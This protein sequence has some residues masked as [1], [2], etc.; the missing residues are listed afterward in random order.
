M[1][2]TATFDNTYD[3]FHIFADKGFEKAVHF[4]KFLFYCMP[5]LFT[6]VN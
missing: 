3:A 6:L 4:L 1:N 5:F 2:E